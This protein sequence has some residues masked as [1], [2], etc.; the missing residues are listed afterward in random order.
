MDAY[1]QQWQQIAKAIMETE[2]N[3]LASAMSA[4][5]IHEL[6]RS[7]VEWFLT[8]QIG[9]DIE[10]GDV[11]RACPEDVEEFLKDIRILIADKFPGADVEDIFYFYKDNPDP[12][13]WE[14]TDIIPEHYG[15][16]H[17]WVQVQQNKSE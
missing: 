2:A 13:G 11:R 16:V 7:S 14:Q 5:E 8:R 6:R 12:D 10:G 1:K 15:P 17:P 4:S 9:K 3:L